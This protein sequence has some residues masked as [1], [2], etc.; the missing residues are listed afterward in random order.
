MSVRVNLLP[1]RIRASRWRRR[2]LAFWSGA[3]GLGAMVAC[4]VGVGTAL[5]ATGGS[6]EREQRKAIQDRERNIV[7]L[8]QQI[9]QGGKAISEVEREFRVARKIHAKP[10]WSVLV[11][12][13]ASLAGEAVA[14]EQCRLSERQA[15]AP[16][17]ARGVPAAAVVRPDPASLLTY[18]L[19]LTG[20]ARSQEEVSAF[21]RR[22]EESELFATTTLVQTRRRTL[23]SGDAVSF[24]IRCE[25]SPMV[26]VR[27]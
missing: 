19:S 5:G 10:D 23:L 21:V 4:V 8:R 26:E 6:A 17:A 18:E 1:L 16:R 27:P 2:A 13:V 9:E 25:L 15:S 11:S 7:Q 22:L 14:I 3:A 20:A 24:E 12:L